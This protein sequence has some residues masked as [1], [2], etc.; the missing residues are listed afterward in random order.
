MPPLR[1]LSQSA[2]Q[3]QVG[4]VSIVDARSSHEVVTVWGGGLFGVDRAPNAKRGRNAEA[5]HTMRPPT[6][7][8]SRDTVPFASQRSADCSPTKRALAG[9]LVVGFA[10]LWNVLCG[11]VVV[12]NLGLKSSSSL[13][14]SDSSCVAYYVA[15]NA[16][17]LL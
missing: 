9:P 1:V 8:H 15:L 14:F 7:G 12:D 3:G 6:A 10:V 2:R 16:S 13:L 4:T 5:R 17:I 11:V